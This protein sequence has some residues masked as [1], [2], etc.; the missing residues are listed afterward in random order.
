V[1]QPGDNSTFGEHK[2][3]P[4]CGYHETRMDAPYC[5][6]CGGKHTLVIISELRYGTVSIPVVIDDAMPPGTFKLVSRKR[7]P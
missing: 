4:A 3:C 6:Y 2:L 1:R 5:S 7:Y